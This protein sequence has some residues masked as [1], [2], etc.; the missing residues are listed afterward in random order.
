M[1]DRRRQE[2]FQTPTPIKG[3]NPISGT[4][5]NGSWPNHLFQRSIDPP[6]PVA[7]LP[8]GGTPKIV[9]H[10]NTSSAIFVNLVATRA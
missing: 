3:F 1:V 8:L 2:I 7:A 4:K 6:Q 5:E 9:V 10:P